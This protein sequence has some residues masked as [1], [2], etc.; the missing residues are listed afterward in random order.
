MTAL[1]APPT[2]YIVVSFSRVLSWH[3]Q[4]LL[5]LLMVSAINHPEYNC[6]SVASIAILTVAPNIIVTTTPSIIAA[7]TSIPATA[8]P[9][10]LPLVIIF[11]STS[12]TIESTAIIESAPF[13]L[14]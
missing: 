2:S 8:P 12:I 7:S 9:S 3:L 6:M 1:A 14:M 10:W 5:L 13:I 11:V 4:L